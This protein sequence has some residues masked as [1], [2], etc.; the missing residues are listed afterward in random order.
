VRPILAAVLG[1]ILVLALAAAP[2]AASTRGFDS[3]ITGFSGAYS[4][5]LDG[6]GFLWASDRGRLLET[7]GQNGIYK[8]SPYPSS[9]LLLTPNT[10]AVWGYYI[11]DLQLAIDDHTGEIF[12]AQSNGRTVDIFEEDG[13]FSHEWSSI[14]ES[15]QCGF[16]CTPD[17]H[18]AIDNTNTPSRGRV[19][20]SL[21]SPENDVEVFDAGER[22]VDF[23]ATASYIKNNRL[24]GTPSGRFGQVGFVTVDAS[25]NIYV[26]DWENQEVDEFDSTGTYLRSFPDPGASQG[27]PGRGGVGVDPT[28]GNVLIA[29]GHITEYDENRNLLGTITEDASGNIQ[30]QPSPAV[31]SNGYLYVPNN[32]IV[33]IFKPAAVVPKISYGA[34]GAPS[35][36]AGTLT[37]TV[38]P[39]GGGPVTDCQFEYGTS[40]SYGSTAACSPDP[41]SSPPGS[42]F[43]SPTQ[44][45]TA[46]SGLT[47][48]TTYHYRVV[49][50]NANGVRYG[51]DQTYTPHT[52]VGLDT[53]PA[54]GLSE[55][56]ATLNGS[57]VG[58]GEDTKYYFEWG[59]TAAYGSSTAISDAGSPGGPSRTALAATLSGLAPYSTYHY[60]VVAENGSGTA[61][62]DDLKFTTSPGVP[63]GRNPAV[64]V[65][66]ADRAVLHGE[67]D[68]NGAV[69]E[70][71]FEY[72]T[73]PDFQ[74]SG[75]ANAV[76]TNP[77]EVGMSKH[78]QTVNK[79][80]SGL[81]AGTLY[82]FRL[83]GENSVGTGDAE[84][85][86]TT[87]GFTP[88][89]NDRCPNSHVRQ[90]TGTSLLL[91]CRA[92]ELV[93]AE[94]AGG[95][96]V[97]ST[98]VAGEKPFGEYPEAI[99]PSQVLYGIHGG[100]VPGVGHPTNRGVDPYVATRGPSGW[101]TQ[102]VGIPADGTP[103][104]QS[105]A[106]T[107]NEAD[108]SLGTFAFGGSEIC[109]PCFPD[110]SRGEPTHLPD[111][112]LIQ[113][114]AGS[115]AQPGAEPAG[116][117][118]RH[119]SA[120]GFH[121]VFGS[122]SQ[123]E[124]DGNNN[125][126]VSIYDRNLN[127]DVTHVVS[128]TPGATTMT[129]PG[130]G[131]LDISSN[132]SRIVIG[133]LMSTDSEGNRYWHL[134]MNV[135]D[136]G[137]TID[138]TPGTTSGA[139]YNGMTADGSNVFFTTVDQLSGADTDH[140]ADIYDAEVDPSGNFSLR[141]VSTG[142]GGTGNT[143]ACNPSANTVHPIWN[144][145]GSVPSCGVVAVGGGGGVAS[146]SQTIYF[147]SPE[148]LDGPGNGVQDAPN[149][150]VSRPGDRPRF[151][152]TLESSSNAPLPPLHHA[153]LHAIGSGI[154]NPAGVAIDDS[155]GDVYVIDIG[156]QAG[157][158]DV[159]KFDS[160][161][162]SVTNF[163]NNGQ[164]A[165][166]GVYGEANLPTE[167]AVDQSNG[168]L[169]VP[170]LFDSIVNK[171]SPSGAHIGQM[172]FPFP[173]GVA[174]D[175]SNGQVYVSSAF[176]EVG[177]F[178]ATGTPISSFE[179][180][181]EFPV[182]PTGLAVDSTGKIYVVSGGGFT[183]A[184]G[185][186]EMYDSSGNDL[187]EL[188]LEGA[189]YG[190]AVDPADDHVYIDQGNQFVE[191]DSSGSPIGAPSGQGVL[192]A[193][194]SLAAH[195]GTVEVSN[196][197]SGDVAAFAPAVLPPD[198]RT[199]NPLVV[200][201]VSAAAARKTADFQVT[202]SG[203]HAAFTSTL[204][205]T[206]YDNAPH[207]EV[208][209][210]DAAE[211]RMDCASCNPTSEQATGDASMAYNGLSLVD[212]GR[213]FFNSTEGLVD[214]DLNEKEDAY[215]WEPQGS[216]FAENAQPCENPEG[217]I[218][219]ISTGTSPFPADLLGASADGVDAYFF[220]RDTLVTSDQ[221]GSRVK[222]YDARTEGGYPE[223][224]API[225]CQASDEC[226]GPGSKAPGAPNIQTVSGAPVGN[227]TSTKSAHCRKGRV[228]RHGH[229]VKRH[230]RKHHK[231]RRRHHRKARRHG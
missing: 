140:S 131:E 14:G 55:A 215:E 86:F 153:Y 220:T 152:A 117:I 34:V 168:D 123:F 68:P 159:L 144:T 114:M 211:E 89:I 112:R 212:D 155:N 160:E 172:E 149:L 81:V 199:D 42:Y 62:G 73:D 26:V 92:Y 105:F 75:W 22:P 48:D 217:C 158:G 109:L 6:N 218:E 70:A 21:T 180:V 128:K 107:L 99:G 173:T 53:E 1:A 82:H 141:L 162:H 190:V 130:I 174:V 57:F 188:D 225:P 97:E 135:G 98:L 192:T 170:D 63:T 33:D 106:S 138:L 72:V 52:V 219:L 20:L 230:G 87:F 205:L 49:A 208:Y 137:H 94:K 222:I 146:A 77:E 136:S 47:T 29:N 5:A 223:A 84:K 101:S 163:A 143:D 100:G 110:G 2:A 228:R 209:R 95:Y 183:G 46:A 122:T 61:Q 139:L 74:A 193:S 202:P 214:R 161:G 13:E 124:P 78:Y 176:G 38:D 210:F 16:S 8:Y 224:P 189:A 115:I 80:V 129:G 227:S 197:G 50:H 121:F 186:T 44:V 132:G 93:S 171:Y 91:D 119:L 113:G 56:G 28:N 181:F 185:T 133:K 71:H 226:H 88:S 102:Y 108:A 166:S 54:T 156:G 201:S 60:R 37:A 200:D 45:S 103:S 179:T 4:V 65:V 96:D 25:G 182:G 18:I 147:L 104:T 30:D 207:R 127:T 175:Q 221:N 142:V 24:T 194:I 187:G 111:G 213:V 31:N 229:C 125:G 35:P 231:A 11:L 32:D 169:Y 23:P 150:Y 19:Y 203:D 154:Q 134:Y 79:P 9:S 126:D 198:P 120:D 118:G 196:T 69:T 157:P 76:S 58:G 64:T 191:L 43:S 177:I 148:K 184:P 10:Y 39:N 151:I 41:A 67:V 216:E 204:S 167:L 12:V 164:L 90:Q 40:S 51:A 85:T 27:Y 165:V 36:T 145:T 66:H 15:K 17:I 206:G 3:K 116:F 195:A 7:P 83:V 59:P 178:T